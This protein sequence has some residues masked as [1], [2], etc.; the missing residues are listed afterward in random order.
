MRAGLL[1]F[2]VGPFGVCCVCVLRRLVLT[3]RRGVVHS[4]L[5][6]YLSTVDGIVKLHALSQWLIPVCNGIVKLHHLR[7][8]KL[9]PKRVHDHDELRIL[10]NLLQRI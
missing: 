2:R 9:L 5:E 7:C 4:M 6:R 8:W 3:G 1:L 10:N